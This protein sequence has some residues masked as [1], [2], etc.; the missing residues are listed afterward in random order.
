MYYVELITMV[1]NPRDFSWLPRLFGF[2][3][4]NLIASA[5]VFTLVLL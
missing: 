2:K 3:F 5:I 1:E 4:E